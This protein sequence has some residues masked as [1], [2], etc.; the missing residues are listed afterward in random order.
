[1]QLRQDADPGAGQ[2]L[3]HGAGERQQPGKI[4]VYSI[5]DGTLLAGELPPNKHKLVVA[6]IEIHQEDLLADWSLAVNGKKPFPI[7]GLD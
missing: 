7:K 6:W 4:A 2:L 5:F 1:M 3:R